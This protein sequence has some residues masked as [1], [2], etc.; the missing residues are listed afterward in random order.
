M[1]LPVTDSG[2]KT[3]EGMCDPANGNNIGSLE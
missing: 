2:S 1:F 3:R